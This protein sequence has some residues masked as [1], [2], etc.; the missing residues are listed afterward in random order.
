MRTAARV[1]AIFPILLGAAVCYFVLAKAVEKR[2]AALGI[3]LATLAPYML[4]T[5]YGGIA[6]WW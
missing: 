3:V 4:Y 5:G 6:G 2:D 1:A